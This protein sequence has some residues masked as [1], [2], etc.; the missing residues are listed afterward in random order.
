MRTPTPAPRAARSRS[1]YRHSQ[2]PLARRDD[3]PAL[4]NS[5]HWPGCDTLRCRTN[6]IGSHETC[7]NGPTGI[8]TAPVAVAQRAGCGEGPSG[9]GRDAA[10]QLLFTERSYAGCESVVCCDRNEAAFW[11]AAVAVEHL[12]DPAE[13]PSMLERLAK[14]RECGG[15]LRSHRPFEGAHQRIEE[16]RC[17][18][19]GDRERRA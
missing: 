14:A 15:H 10:G 6:H 12:L 3:Y 1:L 4:P 8:S 5:P 2:R 13:P 17:S 18:E 9:D 11:C 19:G 16:R 7:F